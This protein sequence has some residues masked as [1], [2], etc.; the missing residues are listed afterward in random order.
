MAIA[1]TSFN[2]V[3]AAIVAIPVCALY[4]IACVGRGADE[5]GVM[6]RDWAKEAE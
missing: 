1:Q 4:F 3:R 5:L 6:L 2:R